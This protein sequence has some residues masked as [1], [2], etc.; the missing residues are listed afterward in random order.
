VDTCGTPPFY[1]EKKSL[2]L[3][4]FLFL[5]EKDKHFSINKHMMVQE[6]DNHWFRKEKRMILFKNLRS[7][8][9]PKRVEKAAGIGIKVEGKVSGLFK[10]FKFFSSR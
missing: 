1:A 2:V 6:P 5:S 10:I 8:C 7:C 4:V 9:M 3:A